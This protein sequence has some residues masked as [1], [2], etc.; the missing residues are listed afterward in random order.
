MAGSTS[1]INEVFQ[2]IATWGISNSLSYWHIHTGCCADEVLNASGAKY[3]LERF[4]CTP[5]KA[6]ESADLLIVSGVVTKKLAPHLI[7]TF[8][9]MLAPK[10]LI[11]LGSCVVGG[12]PFQKQAVQENIPLH[13]ILPVDVSVAGNPPRPEAV[14][15]GII[16]LREKICGR[17]HFI[18][19]DQ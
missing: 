19:K 16:Q 18:Q 13:K 2:R 1:S 15:Y 9:K 11:A 7:A 3:D 12:G 4:G 6:I 17:T 8:E 5:A 10:F 14:M